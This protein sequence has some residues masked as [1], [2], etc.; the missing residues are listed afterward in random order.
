M[1][2][3]RNRLMARPAALLALAIMAMSYALAYLW[4][5]GDLAGGGWG[6]WEASFPAW[7]RLFER[8]GFLQFEPVGRIMLGSLVWTFS[9]LNTLVALA[10]GGL[11]GLNLLAAWWVWR[12][13]RVCGV[14]GSAGGILAAIPAL[15]VGGACCA[16]LVLIWLGLPI[17]GA[18]VGLTPLLIPLAL[19]LM[20]AG[21][22]VM[23]RRLDAS[24]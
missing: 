18:V 10:M 23:S 24:G 1:S 9:P 4:L 2:V 6:G 19:V 17:A 20:L 13:P 15:L 21:L 16:P 5:T 7:E 22:W 14:G 12:S 3:F 8:R 11:L